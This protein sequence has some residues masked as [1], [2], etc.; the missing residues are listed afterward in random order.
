M[1][2]RFRFADLLRPRVSATRAAPEA[3]PPSIDAL[4]HISRLWCDQANIFVKGWAHAYERPVTAL[5][6]EVG[7]VHVPITQFLPTPYL[8]DYFPEYPHLARA[9]FAV[10]VPSAPQGPMRLVIE[11]AAGRVVREFPNDESMAA[12]SSVVDHAPKNVFDGFAMFVAAI[13]QRGTPVV[14]LRGPWDHPER[15]RFL[16]MIPDYVDF[17]EYRL[18]TPVETET[19]DVATLATHLSSER[20]GIF[21]LGLLDRVP[22]PWRLV[23]DGQ[24]ALRHHG[25][26]FH[27]VQAAGTHA[28]GWEIGRDGL[29]RLISPATMFDTVALGD[30]FDGTAHWVLARKR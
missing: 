19:P 10:H 3:A 24:S 22:E 20:G 12:R 8:L 5:A 7:G 13:A 23:A 30:C 27:L 17:S 18:G 2:G 6:I 14:E 21:S 9:G 1:T 25:A 15:A 4:H 26:F 11:T 29:G 28:E 16:A